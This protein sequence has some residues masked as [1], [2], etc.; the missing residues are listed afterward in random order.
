MLGKKFKA[1]SQIMIAVY[2]FGSAITYVIIIGEQLSSGEYHSI[3]VEEGLRC[4]TEH[5]LVRK[6]KRYKLGIPNLMKKF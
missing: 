3:N 4:I 5:G 2:F 1:I 6:R